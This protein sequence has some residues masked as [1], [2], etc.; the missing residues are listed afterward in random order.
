[1]WSEFGNGISR[2]A[3]IQPLASGQLLCLSSCRVQLSDLQALAFLKRNLLKLP[4]NAQL[5]IQSGRK[6]TSNILQTSSRKNGMIQPSSRHPG[7]EPECILELQLP[8]SKSSRAKSHAN[9]QSFATIKIAERQAPS[10]GGETC[11]GFVAV[12]RSRSG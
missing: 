10:L 4:H 3:I 11:F 9:P 8:P 2:R 7:L 5:I 6:H 12:C 1:M